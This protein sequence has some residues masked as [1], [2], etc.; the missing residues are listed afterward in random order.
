MGRKRITILTPQELKKSIIKYSFRNTNE[1]IPNR[2]MINN[3][4]FM[5]ETGLHRNFK[6]I[7]LGTLYYWKKVKLGLDD[8]VMLEAYEAIRKHLKLKEAI[9]LEELEKMGYSKEQVE[10]LYYKARAGEL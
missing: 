1:K 10:E 8:D 9:S 2:E 6:P 7:S 5:K 3:I 4:E